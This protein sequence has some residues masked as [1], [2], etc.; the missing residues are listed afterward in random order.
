VGGHDALSERRLKT[1]AAIGFKILKHLKSKQQLMAT[2]GL[3]QMIVVND[4]MSIEIAATLN[5]TRVSKI[6]LNRQKTHIFQGAVNI[7]LN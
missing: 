5:A 1:E 7:L 6:L 4:H 3:Q 2:N